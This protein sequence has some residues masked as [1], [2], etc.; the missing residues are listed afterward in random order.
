MSGLLARLRC[1]S[2]DLLLSAA[3]LAVMAIMPWFC[4]DRDR[5]NVLE[6]GFN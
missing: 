2:G 6:R 4:P 3:L 5:M 1:H